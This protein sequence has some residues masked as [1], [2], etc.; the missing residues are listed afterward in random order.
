MSGTIS[1]TGANGGAGGAATAPVGGGGGGSGG[2]ILL[3]IVNATL[4]SNLVTAIGGSGGARSCS[5][6]V[7]GAGGGGGGVG[8]IAVETGSQTSVT[9][10]PAA[11]L[12]NVVSDISTTW[13]TNEGTSISNLTKATTKRLRIEM[14]NEGDTSSGDVS[15]QLQVSGPDPASCEA[16]SYTRVDSS[17]DWSVV[18]SSYITDG[19]STANINPG[20]TDENTTFVSGYLEESSDTLASTV[21]LGISDFTEIEYALQAN[22]G[23]TDGAVYC[24]RLTNAGSTTNFAYDLYPQVGVALIDNPN[25]QHYRWRNDDGSETTATWLAA[26]DTTA[27]LARSTTKRLRMEISSEGL[28]DT[29][30]ISYQLQVSQANPTSCASGTYTGVS[31]SSEW[32]IAASGNFADGAATTNVASGLTDENT[33]FVAGLMEETSDT[34]NSTIDLTNTQFTEMEWA[35]QPTSSAVGQATYCFR[36]TNAGSTLHF[37]YVKYVEA[38]ISSPNTTQVHYR[39]RND[40]GTEAGIN[41]GD[42]CRLE[43]LHHPVHLT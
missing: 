25:Q 16:A 32:A 38:N 36:L 26:E 6:E 20:L 11:S 28:G 13:Y 31:S 8:R 40:N 5:N 18:A 21:A 43:H 9:T 34:L 7:C 33:T 27:Y 24:F 14:S 15:Y 30:A 35:L 42:G 10:N 41:T 19:S 23:A 39:W 2:S 12:T 29:G 37:T 22:A 17:G 3:R 1:S 4:G